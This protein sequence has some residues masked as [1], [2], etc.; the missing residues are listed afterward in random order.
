MSNL[1]LGDV[2]GQITDKVLRSGY[3]KGDIYKLIMD[4]I[5]IGLVVM[6]FKQYRHKYRNSPNNTKSAIKLG[7]SRGTFEEWRKQYK[8]ETNELLQ[9]EIK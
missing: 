3:E 2:I 4:D 9:K 7:I 6:C 8:N 1:T 5:K